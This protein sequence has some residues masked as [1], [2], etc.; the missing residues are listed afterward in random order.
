MATTSLQLCAYNNSSVNCRSDARRHHCM[1]MHKS[2]WR[3]VVFQEDMVIEVT[4][5]L[6]VTVLVRAA[7]MVAAQCKHAAVLAVHSAEPFS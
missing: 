6:L 5:A 3:L 4:V 2:L 7:Q 1:S